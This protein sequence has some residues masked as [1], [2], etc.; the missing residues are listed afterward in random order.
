MYSLI[1]ENGEGNW[2]Y[3]LWMKNRLLRM[4][5]KLFVGEQRRSK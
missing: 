5:R 4:K 2:E 3:P 1:L